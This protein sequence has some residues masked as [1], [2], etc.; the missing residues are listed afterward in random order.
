MTFYYIT[1]HYLESLCLP[2][3]CCV[4]INESRATCI[5][6]YQYP[7]GWWG[8]TNYIVTSLFQIS[9]DV[10]CAIKIFVTHFIDTCLYLFAYL[11][12][13]RFG[14][15]TWYQEAPWYQ[16]YIFLWCFVT[17]IDYP[18]HGLWSHLEKKAWNDSK[19]IYLW[20]ACLVCVCLFNIY[21]HF[22][23]S[24]STCFFVTC[25]RFG[26]GFNLCDGYIINTRNIFNVCLKKYSSRVKATSY[27]HLW[28]QLHLSGL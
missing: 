24:L 18:P 5:N 20:H 10:Y 17:S 22:D 27:R 2:G 12:W 23:Y 19:A 4:R 7:R 28:R 3:F 8:W 15:W 26:S 13:D 1:L 9:K 25:M 6:H 11:M 16:I 21:R 14:D